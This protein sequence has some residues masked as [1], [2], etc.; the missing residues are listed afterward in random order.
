LGRLLTWKGFEIGLRAFARIHAEVPGAVY[1]IVGDGPA[2]KRLETVAQSLGIARKVEF[3][4]QLPRVQALE[5]LAQSTVLIHPSLHDSG[6]WVCLE[7]MAAGRPVICLDVG[8]PAT[9]VTDDTGFRIK[10]RSPEQT[11][12]EI[13]GVM[14]ILANNRGLVQRMGAAGRAHLAR[15]Y[16]LTGLA[17]AVSQLYSDY[18]RA[19]RSAREVKIGA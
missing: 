2:R 15:N 11:I 1:S 10:P 16:S 14:G 18:A 3:C 7:A 4:G 17:A 6:G 19:S 12:E 5:K 9:Q 8:G 13:A